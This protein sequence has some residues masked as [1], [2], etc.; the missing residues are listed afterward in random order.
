MSAIKLI[1]WNVNGVRAAMRNGLITTI[2]GFTYD[3][4]LL[5][6]VKADESQFPRELR[7]V[8]RATDIFPAGKKGY[9]GVAALSRSNPLNAARGINAPEFDSEGRV[10]TVEFDR[11][12]LVNAYFPNSQR[13]LTRLDYKLEF[14]RAF[15]AYCNRLSKMKPLVICGDFNVA[16]EEIDIARPDQNRHN[17]GFTDEERRWMTSFLNEGYMDTFRIFTKEP[18]HYTWWSYMFDARKKNIG[19]RID[20]FLVSRE[21]AG[22]VVSAGILDQAEGSDHAPITLELRL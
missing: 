3:I 6:E 21:I 16:H 10:Q 2:A 12:F 19:W 1:S 13:G 7:N 11:F 14:N 22:N 20:Y 15:Q 8:H 18:G 5:Q 4:L 17:A 9:S